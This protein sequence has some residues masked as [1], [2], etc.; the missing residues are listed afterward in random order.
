MT[1]LL[2]LSLFLTLGFYGLTPNPPGIHYIQYRAAANLLMSGGNPYDLEEQS[3]L[4][5]AL[6]PGGSRPF[7]PYYYPPWF[8]IACAPLSLLPYPA[9]EA[10][11][12]FLISFSLVLSGWLLHSVTGGHSL[13]ATILIVVGFFPSLFAAQTSQT[14]P[15]VLLLTAMT[16]WSLGHGRDWLA[17]MALAAL[18]IKPQLT[19]V[20]VV[21]IL[22]WSARCRRW[23]VI[24]AFAVTLVLFC[25]ASTILFP[26]WPLAMIDAPRRI[27]LPTAIRPQIGVTWPSIVRSLGLVKWPFGIAYASLAIPAA[28]AAVLAS[29]R[30]DARPIDAIGGGAIAAFAM[31]PYAQFYDFPVLL[32][33]LFGLLGNRQPSPPVFALVLA[34]IVLPY[35]NFL[36]LGIARWPPCTFAWVPATL[37]VAWLLRV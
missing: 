10:F 28:A 31:A 20:I 26:G 11:F 23:Q 4:Q 5:R 13:W 14:A 24:Q 1:R 16:W 3:S 27:P 32:V 21:G 33:P 34:F 22:L 9:A 36:A 12:L 37:A 8:A 6:Q 2:I 7:L 29:R 30:Q 17:G 35:L 18:T 25:L 15:L 19:F